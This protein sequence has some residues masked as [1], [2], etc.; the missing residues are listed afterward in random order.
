MEHEPVKEYI[1]EL[2]RRRGK[3][4]LFFVEGGSIVAAATLAWPQTLTWLRELGFE[5][6]GPNKWKT[7]SM[8]AFLEA[9]IL[10]GV[11]QTLRSSGRLSQLRR[12]ADELELLELRFWANKF[13]QGYRGSGRRGM[14]RPARSFK[15][16]YRLAR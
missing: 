15:I 14:Y 2:R 5:E 16:L 10:Y 9:I 12:V 7:G 1:I 11:A 13:S 3:Q 8:T 6:T 4:V